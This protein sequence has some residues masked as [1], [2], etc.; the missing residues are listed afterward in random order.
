MPRTLFDYPNVVGFGTG[1]KVTEG[2]RLPHVARVVLVSRKVEPAAL[3][4]ED[5]IPLEYD[6]MPT[7]VVEV[8]HLRTLQARTDR[9]RPAPGGVSIGHGDVT[10]GTL[11]CIVRDQ[12]GG[13]PLILSNNHVLAN[14]NAGK[15]GD[16][17]YQPGRY[18]GGTETIASLLRWVP[19]VFKEAPGECP[20]AKGAVAIAN[21]AAAMLGSGHRL[22]A[23]RRQE[24]T[25]LF[26][27]AVAR[28]LR[29]DLVVEDILGLS[30]P[31]QVAPEIPLQAELWKSG[32][33]T[34]VTVGQATVVDVTVD[35]DYGGGWTARF[36]GQVVAGPMSQGG[37]SGSVV[38]DTAYRLAGL[39][40]AGSDQ[41]TII[42]PVGPVMAGL[43][44][45][46]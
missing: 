10:A 11:G 27:A 19:I 29:D 12:E 30:Q 5:F 26:D 13:G 16:P 33:T 3:R 28:P 37:D 1:F 43:G 41:A 39:L 25:N 9:W 31:T 2:R 7:D 20:L 6:G 42:S 23:I 14:S 15:E 21:A 46:L 32:R 45:R 34:G 38:L 35:V 44:L 17:I 36:E 4:S 22:Q 40:F 24:A 18:D 8:G